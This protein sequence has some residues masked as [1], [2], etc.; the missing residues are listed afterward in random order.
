M[1]DPGWTPRNAETSRIIRSQCRIA[2]AARRE[3]PNAWTNSTCNS[4]EITQLP[5]ES[6]SKSSGAANGPGSDQNPL[7]LVQADGIAGAVIEVGRPPPGP[8]GRPSPAGLGP[9]GR[10]GRAA[11]GK[12]LCCKPWPLPARPARRS[13]A[14]EGMAGRKGP[15][16]PGCAATRDLRSAA[17][18]QLY[19]RF[20]S[21]W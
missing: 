14:R 6:H 1:T 12:P 11:A 10:P 7:D 3:A 8:N 17:R 15:S 5:A 19:H 16:G 13:R 2:N 21:R 20:A 4:T 9:R 18:A